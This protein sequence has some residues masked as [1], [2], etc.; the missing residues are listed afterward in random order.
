MF[1]GAFLL[2]HL[3]IFCLCDIHFL[4]S[5]RYAPLLWLKSFHPRVSWLREC[6]CA[7][8]NKRR[9][10]RWCGKVWSFRLLNF[11]FRSCSFRSS[12]PFSP[13]FCGCRME[14]FTRCC[15]FFLFDLMSA[16]ENS[17]FSGICRAS[18]P[19][20]QRYL[21]PAGEKTF[22]AFHRW[23]KLSFKICKISIFC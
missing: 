13:C 10:R 2:H 9:R 17:K 11:K 8:V 4:P 16:G 21:A 15:V 7:K 18:F 20:T 23:T 1:S 3:D 6:V 5:C 14:S 12:F 19:G 22:S